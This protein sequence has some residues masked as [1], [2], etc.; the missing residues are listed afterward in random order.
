MQKIQK[1][2][3]LYITGLLVVLSLIR[4]YYYNHTNPEGGNVAGI[5]A[6]K[7]QYWFQLHR[8]SNFEYFYFGEPGNIEASELLRTFTVKTGVPGKKP[9]PLPQLVGRD[10]WLLVDK[11]ESFENPETAPYFL[12]LD[13]PI[14]EAEPY[15]PEPYLECDGQC[16]WEL[17]GY[18]GLHGIASD[19]SKLAGEN[20]GSSGCVRHYDKDIAYLYNLLDPK[21]EQIRYYIVDK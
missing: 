21:E 20:E 18:F 6:Q 7:K 13:V 8:K 9:T 4:F 17:P 14:P 3:I 1:L 12:V 11:M 15:G 5:Q 16:N 2:N 10:Y 19:E